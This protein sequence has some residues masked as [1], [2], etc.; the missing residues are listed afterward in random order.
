MLLKN[1]TN[2]CNSS[3][4]SHFVLFGVVVLLLIIVVNSLAGF[5]GGY[6]YYIFYQ[7]IYGIGLSILVPLIYVFHYEKNTLAELGFKRI[8]VKPVAAAAFFICFSIGGQLIHKSINIPSLEQLTY[9]SIPLIMTTFFEDRFEKLFGA[10]PAI[11]LS[12]LIFSLYHLGYSDFRRWDSLLTLFLVGM[13]FALSFKLSGNHLFTSYFVNLP[14][15]ILTYLLNPQMFPPFT[16]E[17]A[18]VSFAVIIFVLLIFLFFTNSH[19]RLKLTTS[20]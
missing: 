14:N 9:I 7:G 17:T 20:V 3:E 4:K 8:T 15:A 6:L 19:R 16:K 13:M 12:G 18:I 5:F 11:V 2:T 10:L 1:G